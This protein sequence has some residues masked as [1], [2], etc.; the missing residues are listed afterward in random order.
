MP[1]VIIP[2]PQKFLL[3]TDENE[4]LL[5]SSR[6]RRRVS[7]QKRSGIFKLRRQLDADDPKRLP[8]DWDVRVKEWRNRSYLLELQAHHGFFLSMGV[9]GWDSFLPAIYLLEDDPLL[10]TEMLDMFGYLSARLIERVLR[11]V[12][13][14]FVTFSEPIGGN[15]GPLLS[16]E[17]YRRFVTRSYVPIV[18]ALR[19][20]GVETIVFMTYANSRALIPCVL[21][22]GFNC[23][24]AC[25]TEAK[26]MDYKSLRSEFGPELRL[27]GGIDS[28][29]LLGDK[30]MIRREIETKVPPL[31][32]QGGYIPVA[33]GRVRANVPFE[34]FIYY[35][36]LLAEITTRG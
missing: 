4:C 32:E 10:V 14:D 22:I 24:W 34:N 19:R 30:K 27:I 3:L 11:E 12:E 23:L 8:K 9:E 7:C 15:D 26:A 6:S 29:A 25:E 13:L 18:D 28:D 17:T 1:K 31:L 5:F 21:E 2:T 16:P 20:G 35:R 33:D 36:E